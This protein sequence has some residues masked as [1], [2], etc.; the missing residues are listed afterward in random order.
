MKEVVLPFNKFPGVDPL[1]HH[2]RWLYIYLGAIAPTGGIGVADIKTPDIA[3]EIAGINGIGIA[4]TIL[5]DHRRLESPLMAVV[6]RAVSREP[7]RAF[8]EEG[9]F[10]GEKYFTNREVKG[11]TAAWNITR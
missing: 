7:V 6:V 11:L 3:F 1:L 9:M 2:W 8:M 10:P 4:I 5:V